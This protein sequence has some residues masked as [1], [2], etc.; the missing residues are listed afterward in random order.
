MIASEPVAP[1]HFLRSPLSPGHD[2]IGIP[3]AAFD[4]RRPINAEHSRPM[5][6]DLK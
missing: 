6:C 4:T 2:E 1:S 3:Q 5:Q